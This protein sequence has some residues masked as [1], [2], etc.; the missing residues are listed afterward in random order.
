ME[1]MERR[2]G[3]AVEHKSLVNKLADLVK[4][5]NKDILFV[6]DGAH[7]LGSI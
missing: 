7:S 1:K 2:M 4:S 6:V 5:K 3:K